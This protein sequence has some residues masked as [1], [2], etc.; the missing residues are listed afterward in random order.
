MKAVT[1]YFMVVQ[2]ILSV[3]VTLLWLLG[4]TTFDVGA[5]PPT[6]HADF[7]GDGFDDLAVG[8]PFEDIGVISDAGAVNVLY[9]SST[10][11]LSSIGDQFWHQD[12][13]GILDRSETDDNFGYSLAAGDFNGDGFDDLAV[14]VRNEDIG[15]IGD[16]GAVNVL[17]GSA[18]GLS[19]AGNQFWHQDRPGILDR[20][21]A[22]DGFGWALVAGDFNNDGFDDLA[23]GVIGEDIGNITNAGAVNV[24]YGSAT[25]LSSTGNQFLNQNS[26]GILD[27][28]ESGDN[29]GSALK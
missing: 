17:Y 3:F 13:P 26:P 29:F 19:S 18:T 15:T 22:F 5:A 25:G 7:N 1:K 2:I 14:G 10:I 11:G 16:A 12:S 8:V 9:G 6:I 4:M 20:A 24:L 23:V 28:A 27:T 21:E